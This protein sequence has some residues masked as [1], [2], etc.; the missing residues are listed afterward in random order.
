MSATSPLSTARDAA[1]VGC[2]LLALLCL[3]WALG[4]VSLT[5]AFAPQIPETIRAGA[6]EGTAGRL[7]GLLPTV[8]G[9]AFN[10]AGFLVF[11]RGAGWIAAKM[12][13]GL[14]DAA[15]T[16]WARADVLTMAVTVFGLWLLLENVSHAVEL[17]PLSLTQDLL[18]PAI[19]VR[20]LAALTIGLLC[21]IGSRSIAGF[22]VKL[23]RW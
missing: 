3:Y 14:P 23:R 8:F 12:V 21:L 15:E 2:R 17:A 9:V 13:R 19:S 11:W 16:G 5:A 20:L 18:G 10:L 1:F 7:L 4:Y 6:T 22:V